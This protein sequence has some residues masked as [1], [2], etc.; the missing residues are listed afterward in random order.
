MNKA[1]EEVFEGYLEDYT[2]DDLFEELD[3]DP[4][5]AIMALYYAGMIDEEKLEIYLEV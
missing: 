1:L 3:I 5:E 4:I 2:V